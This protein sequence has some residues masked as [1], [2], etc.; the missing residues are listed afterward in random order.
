MRH[1][2]GM[3]VAENTVLSLTLADMERPEAVLAGFFGTYSLAEVREFLWDLVARGLCASDEELGV[4][5]RKEILAGY[6]GLER[7]LEAAYLLHSRGNCFTLK[8]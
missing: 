6:E 7:L 8:E 2:N 1:A 3:T 5:G 4:F